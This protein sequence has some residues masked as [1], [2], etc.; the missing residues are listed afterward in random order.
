MQ[1]QTISF[2]GGRYQLPEYPFRVPRELADGVAQRHCVAIVGAGLVGLTAA[3][4]LAELGI[5]VVVLDEDNNVG[6]RGVSSR[7][8]S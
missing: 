1:I 6:A 5:S 2:S 3:C 7:G 4:S 8:V